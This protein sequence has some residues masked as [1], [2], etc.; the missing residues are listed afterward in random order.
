MPIKGTRAMTSADAMRALLASRVLPVWKSRST[1]TEWMGA[2]F[3]GRN[4]SPVDE[5][6]GLEGGSV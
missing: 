1:C 3:P 6:K 2:P 4:M 5:S